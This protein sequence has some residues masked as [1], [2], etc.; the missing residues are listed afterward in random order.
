MRRTAIKG[1][2]N[3]LEAADYGRASCY[4]IRQLLAGLI[5]KASFVSPFLRPYVNK[6]IIKSRRKRI[7]VGK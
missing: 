7:Y 2:I 4:C 6:N 3:I 5:L 1:F